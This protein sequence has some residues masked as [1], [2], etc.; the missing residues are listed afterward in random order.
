MWSSS[1]LITAKQK[2][3]LFIFKSIK[4]TNSEITGIRRQ[5]ICQKE[6]NIYKVYP[7]S[8]I[9]DGMIYQEKLILVSSASLLGKSIIQSSHVHCSS[10]GT[11]MIEMF[12]LNFY[13]TRCRQQFRKL[14]LSCTACARLRKSRLQRAQ[15]ASRQPSVQCLPSFAVCSMDVS[16][17]HRV[18]LK[19]NTYRK[20]FVLNLNCVKTRYCRL[21]PLQDMTSSSILLAIKQICFDLG[22]SNPKILFCDNQSSFLSIKKLDDDNLSLIHI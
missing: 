17:P 2:A 9:K 18:L 15:G 3:E 12:K 19:R 16:G 20:L 11:E 21:L 8:F 1:S 22:R 10:S 5:Y 7:R 4:L 14:Q 6:D 13:V